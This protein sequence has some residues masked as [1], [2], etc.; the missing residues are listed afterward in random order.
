MSLLN[1]V[2]NFSYNDNSNACSYEMFSG[3]QLVTSHEKSELTFP[4]SL[5]QNYNSVN[6]N[7]ENEISEIEKGKS[8][9]QNVVFL[10]GFYQNRNENREIKSHYYQSLRHEMVKS[11]MKLINN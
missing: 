10:K 4:L 6:E 1:S 7:P 5:V 11:Y 8:Q 2:C 9:N 3:D